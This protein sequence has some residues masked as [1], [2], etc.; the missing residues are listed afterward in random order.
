MDWFLDL[1]RT[2]ILLEYVL[3]SIQDLPIDQKYHY[4]NR[5]FF[6]L[7]IAVIFLFLQNIVDAAYYNLLITSKHIRPLWYGHF[8]GSTIGL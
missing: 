3:L 7:S 6:F 2:S 4:T 1:S 8:Q 5:Y